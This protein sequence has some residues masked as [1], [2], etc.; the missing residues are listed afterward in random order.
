MRVG[1]HYEPKGNTKM[2][3]FKATIKENVVDVFEFMDEHEN[4]NKKTD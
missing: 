1:L 4:D 2:K 3:H